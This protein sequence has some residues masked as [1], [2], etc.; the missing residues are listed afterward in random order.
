MSYGLDDT[1]A[2]PVLMITT[3]A[4]RE[5]L[6]RFFAEVTPLSTIVAASGPSSARRYQAF[7]LA[8]RQRAIE[9]LRPCPKPATP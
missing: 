9:P 5:R 7:R 4:D 8:N 2:G 1:A 6:Q 3:C